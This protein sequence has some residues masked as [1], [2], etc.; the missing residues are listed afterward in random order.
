MNFEDVLVTNSPTREAKLW[1]PSKKAY[2]VPETGI[3]VVNPAALN[4]IKDCARIAV[5]YT[6]LKVFGLYAN[7]FEEL[8]GKFTVDQIKEFVERSKTELHTRQLLRLIIDRGRNLIAATPIPTDS[9]YG[10]YDIA[11]KTIVDEIYIVSKLFA[12]I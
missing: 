1:E 3:T 7:P 11:E 4:V 2:S 10:E 9:P 12:V 6:P 5:Q 8:K